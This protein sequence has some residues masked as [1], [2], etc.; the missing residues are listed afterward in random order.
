M[1]QSRPQFRDS[2]AGAAITVQIISPGK[3][4]EIVGVLEDGTI[5]ICLSTSKDG[6]QTNPKLVQFLAKVFDVSPAQ[7]E[8][9]AGQNRPEKLIA[10]TGIDSDTAQQR[11]SKFLS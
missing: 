10:I 5:K 11:I 9:I 4:D 1:P 2:K 6:S 7:I 8:I 3:K